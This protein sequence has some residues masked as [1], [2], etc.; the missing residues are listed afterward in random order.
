M[1]RNVGLVVLLVLLSTGHAFAQAAPGLQD[2]GVGMY[3]DMSVVFQASTFT[4]NPQMVSCGVGTLVPGGALGAF[5]MLMYSVSINSY[6]L[7]RTVPRRIIATGKMRSITRVAGLVIED[8]DGSFL[9]QPPHD[10]IAVAEDKDN[11]QKDR[12]SV[13]FKTNFWK[14]G[15]PMCTASELFPGLC[16]FGGDVF[17]GNVVVSNGQTF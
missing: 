1:K 13:H 3:T 9:H 14:P 17:L 2:E 12:F 8:T 16:R 10:F 5:E 11:P 6:T 7:E 15:N 4:I